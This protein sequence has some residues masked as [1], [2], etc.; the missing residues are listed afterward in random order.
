MS[1]TEE[2]EQAV[3]EEQEQASN[4]QATQEAPAE[5]EHEPVKPGNWR[6][7]IPIIAFAVGFGAHFFPGW[8][9]FPQLLYGKKIQPIDFNHKLHVE[10]MGECEGCHYFRDDG[11]FAGVPKLASCVECHEEQLGNHPEEAKLIKEYVEPGKEIPWLIYSRQPQCVF[12]SHAAHV[13][14]GEMEC[15]TCHGPVGDSTD[16]KPYQYNRLT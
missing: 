4:E 5:E 7:L 13:T 16:L 2:K 11:S 10:E 14:I 1:T 8:I 15:V 6:F 12:F 9:L 3:A